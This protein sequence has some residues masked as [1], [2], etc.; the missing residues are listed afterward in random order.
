M[1]DTVCYEDDVFWCSLLC[2][3]LSRGIFMLHYYL[4]ID[5]SKGYADFVLVNE[6]QVPVANGFQ[7]DDTASGHHHLLTY[8]HEFVT[9]HPNVTISA[10]LEST[11]GYENNWYRCLSTRSH[12][13]SG[14]LES[15]TRQVQQPGERQAQL[16]GSN[17][18]ARCRR[19]FG[20]PCRQSSLQ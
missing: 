1:L 8:L 16:H 5:A 3:T 19:V 7:L 6:Q 20:D 15:G 11:G 18:R 12:R 13:S 17:Q 9:A 14:A 4:G 10:A 2:S